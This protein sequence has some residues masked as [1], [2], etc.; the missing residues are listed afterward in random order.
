MLELQPRSRDSRLWACGSPLLALAVTL[1]V[2]VALF[3]ALGKDPVRG[4]QMFFWEPVKTPYALGE[5]MVKAT[6]LLLIALGLALCFRSN[7]WN[8]GAEGQ[9]VVGAVAAGGV[10]LLA[11]KSTGSWI[12]PALLLAGA[13][14]GMAWAGLTALLRDRFHANEILVSLM[15]VYVA[16]QLLGYLVHGPWK[17]PMG[18]NFPQTRTFAQATQIPRLVPGS[19]MTVGLLLALAGAGALWVFLF[20]TRAGFAQ[21]VG[22]L[23]PAA[24]RYAGFSPRR[25]LWT[26][27]LVSGATAGLAGALEVAGPI[28]QLTP[29]VPS[30]YGFAAII[31]AFVGRLHPLGMILSAILMSMFYIGGELAQSRLGLPKSLT[32]V[33]LGLLLFTLLAC[34]TLIAYRVRRVATRRRGGTT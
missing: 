2:G 3:A 19:R 22:G 8:I 33:F 6:P 20:R 18:Y 11:D 12:V 14:G 27:L 29:H 23:A 7:V 17:D 26:A 5:L 34:D 21:Q 16:V 15:L 13:L 30:G 4:L 9:F 1:L 10:A 25:A 28:G 24:A 32:N 31:V